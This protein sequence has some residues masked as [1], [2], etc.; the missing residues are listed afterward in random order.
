[1][2]VLAEDGVHL[3]QQVH[4]MPRQDT[5]AK[6][7]RRRHDAAF[8]HELIE[9]SLQPGASVSAIALENG[10]NTNLLFKWRRMHLRAASRV[11]D[12]GAAQAVLLPVKLAL[13]HEAPVHKAARTSTTTLASSVIE[14]DIG[15]A[16]VRLRGA[17]DEANVRCVLQALSELA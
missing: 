12:C 1:L 8:K 6:S 16:R 15:A 3:T 14:I 7:T 2:I 13:A 11:E 5:Q 10:I 4:T 17:L 9:R